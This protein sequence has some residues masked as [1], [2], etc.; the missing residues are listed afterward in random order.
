MFHIFL[1][2]LPLPHSYSPSQLLLF[3]K[4]FSI[5]NSAFITF[6]F[7]FARKGG[8]CPH[9]SRSLRSPSL[10][11][12]GTHGRSSTGTCGGA[13]YT[14]PTPG[15]GERARPRG[16]GRDASRGASAEGS[17]RRNQEGTARPAPATTPAGCA[18]SR[19]RRQWP[20]SRRPPDWLRRRLDPA[21]RVRSPPART[22]VVCCSSVSVVPAASPTPGPV[23][24]CPELRMFPE[25]NNLLNTTPDRAEQVRRR[26]VR[27]GRV[28]IGRAHV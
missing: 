15:A 14:A 12:R 6:V 8:G 13:D 16:G 19:V 27:R 5:Y 17:A 20:G 21:L 22:R 3:S 9:S 28:Q 25:L 1:V 2:S 23:R 26:A 24:S 18:S 4:N 10:E 7:R 11:T